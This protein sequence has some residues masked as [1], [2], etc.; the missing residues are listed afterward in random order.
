[1]KNNKEKNVSLKTIAKIY[2]RISKLLFKI[3][4]KFIIFIFISSLILGIVPSISL[5]ITQTMFNAL[6]G[7]TSSIQYIGILLG[8]YILIDIIVT[9]LEIIKNYYTSI[10]QM[11]LSLNLNIKVL[12]KTEKLNLQD[13]EDTDSYNKIQRAQGQSNSEIFKYFL[14]FINI[15]QLFITLVTSSIILL[16]WKWWIVLLIVAISSVNSYYMSKYSKEQYQI[17]RART[18]KER[19]KWYYQYLLIN[20]LAFKEIKMYGLTKYFIKKFEDLGL[21]FMGQDKTIIKKIAKVQIIIGFV[22]QII[23]AFIFCFIVISAFAKSILIGDLV[24]Y[25]RCVSAI[26]SNLNNLLSGLV[27]IIKNSLYISQ[28]FEFLDIEIKEESK[29]KVDLE[30]IEK[31]EIINLSYKYLKSNNYVL[32]NINLTINKGDLI[33]I[34]GRNGSGKSTLIKILSGFYDDYEGDIYINDINIKNIKKQELRKNI[35]ILFQDFTKFELSLREN[36]GLGNIEYINNNPKIKEALA[37]GNIYNKFGDNL[38]TQL[39]FWF[40]NGVQLSGGEWIRVG[41]S[42]ASIRTGSMYIL[43]E[44]NAALDSIAENQIFES[45]K[46]LTKNKIGLIITHRI[47]SIK[48]FSRKIIVLENG[49]ISGIGCHEELLGRCEIYKALYD[50]SIT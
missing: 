27:D 33:A 42:R 46:E 7:E 40:E 35:G 18:E 37:V 1:M 23:V 11:K 3:D 43:D 47:S 32:K 49:V 2:F 25:I 12:N 4:K 13:F 19:Q 36:V 8:L 26:K 31:I 34:V 10:F 17:I 15:I 45:L 50:S 20:D 48:V 14:G 29:D 39:G 24:T 22:E 41:I 6:Q 9:Q 5:V 44:P 38:D 28:L 30:T 16:L 21:Q